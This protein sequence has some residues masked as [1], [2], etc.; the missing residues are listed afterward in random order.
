[1]IKE[2][3]I[4]KTGLPVGWVSKLLGEI[5]VVSAGNSAP[6]KKEL[7]TN[8]TFP[9]IRTS[10]VGK[11]KKG[12]IQSS[13]D[14]LNDEGIKKLRLFKKG[15]ILFPKSGASTFLN[16]RVIM[17]I[18]G[19]VSS[20][21]ATIKPDD[22]CDDKYL[23]YFLILIDAKDLMQDIA[24]PSLKLSDIKNIPI[25][26]P[27]LPQQ[28]KIVAILD[29]AFAAIDTA[30]TNAAQNLLNAKELFESYLQ[31]V[32]ENKGDDWE[33]KTL[34]EVVDIKTGK[35]NSNAMEENGK[36]PF[37]TCSRK[38]FTIN[39]YAFDSKAVLLAGNNASGDF[40]VK[41]YEGKFNAY[42]RTYVI[43]VNSENELLYSYLKH[44]LLF[45]LSVFK[46][47]SVGA[48]TKFLKLG[49]IKGVKIILP[50]IEQQKKIVIKLDF[51]STETK[52]LEAIY[53]QKIADLEE[54]KK[55]VLQKAFSGQ[56]NTLN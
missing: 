28:K 22:S 4:E 56:L 16:H 54:M 18:D 44:K 37:F 43:T 55:S 26:I 17:M 38:I 33:E 34:G 27:A 24:Y 31:N 35:L 39:E 2:L 52:K 25:A 50:P 36:Y 45:H 11:I 13:L 32:F 53:T 51:I 9:F 20:H 12:Q 7:F 3:T 15:T 10:D 41:Y 19:Y 8:G 47:Q 42:Q 14:N 21:L 46:K 40:N 5:S 48:N 6:Q 1:M 23:W 30:K 49:M 29:K